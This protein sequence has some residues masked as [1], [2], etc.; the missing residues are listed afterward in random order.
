MLADIAAHGLDLLLDAAP[1]LLLGL[2]SAG[3]L[4]A[5]LPMGALGRWLGGRGLRPV[6]LAA[7]IGAPLPLCSCGILPAA[8]ALRRAGASREAVTSFLIATPETGVDSIALSYGILGPFFAIARPIAAVL[9]AMATGLLMLILPAD[10]AVAPAPAPGKAPSSCCSKSGCGSSAPVARQSPLRRTLAGLGYAF[11]A[12]FDDLALWLA[13]GLAAAAVTAVLVPPQ[14]LAGWGSGLPAM[15]AVIVLGVPMYIC[16]TASTPLAG[17]LLLAGV[18]PGTVM[19]FLLTGPATNIATIAVVR[20]ELGAAATG[21][22]LGGL[23]VCSLA[24]GLLTD[25]L[26]GYLPLGTAAPWVSAG[27][28]GHGWAEQLSVAFLAVLVAWSLWRR[29]ARSGCGPAGVAPAV[30]HAIV[31]K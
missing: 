12:L 9:S 31:D 14:T 2:A 23:I 11:T 30:N 15:L 18:S 8:V 7:L 4:H 22:Y 5:W 13:I 27:E 29:Y 6:A 3:V 20:R 24:A 26:V 28:T 17:A 25:L 10:P 1:W 21:L 16:A 19:V